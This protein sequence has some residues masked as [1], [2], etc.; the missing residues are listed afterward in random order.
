MFGKKS[1]QHEFKPLLIEIDEEPLNPLGRI[2]FT[3]IIVALIFFSLWMYFGK[4]DVV[5][6]ARGKVIPSGEVKIIQPLTSGVVRSIRVKAGQK[7]EQGEVLMEIDPFDTAPE[8]ESLQSDLQQV[9][10]E[11]L[12]IEALLANQ[13]FLPKAEEYE[14]GQL[15]VQ[16]RL[17]QSHRDKLARQI[18]VK[19]KGLAQIEERLGSAQSGYEEA[20]SLLERSRERLQRL[21]AV[22]DLVSRDDYDQASQEVT[23]YGHQLTAAANTLREI[24]SRWEEVQQEIRLIEEEE[25]NQLL[26]DLARRRQDGS[27]LSARIARTTFVNARQQIRSPV[28]GTVAQLLV[29]TVGGVVTPAEK[30]AIIVPGDT[31]L[32]VKALVLNKDVG[33][34]TPGMAVAI[35][36]DTFEFQK[37]GMLSGRLLEVAQDSIEDKELGLVYEAYVEPLQT[38]LQVEGVATPIST[39]MTVAAEI[40]V[41]KRRIIEFF[42][43]P[44]IKYFHEGTSVR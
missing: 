31:A 25:R 6:T 42:L 10:L 33:Y 8:L 27:T 20:T 22:R 41:G 30:L 40:K 24:G 29:H 13:P 26:V 38:T 43:Y 2:I 18:V 15:F 23:T 7:V 9:E 14:A 44:L 35:K 28:R 16:R 3:V 11:I 5:V 21:E 4:I 39:G 32:L 17:Y 37:F 36:V 12:R 1:D 34:L 19:E